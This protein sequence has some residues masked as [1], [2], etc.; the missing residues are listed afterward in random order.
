MNDEIRTLFPA[1]AHYTYLNSA[2][3]SPMPR[4]AAEAVT[5]Q[6]YDV[7]T[8]GSLHYLDWIATKNRAR[9]LIAEMLNVRADQIAFMRNTSDGVAAIANGVDWAEGDNIVSFQNEF[10]ANF[11]PWRSVRDR[12]GVELRLA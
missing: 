5:T 8:H 3:V 12:F 4:T 6:L 7:S 2:A 10:P 1:L 9:D 11:Y